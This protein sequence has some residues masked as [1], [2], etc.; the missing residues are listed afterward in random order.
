LAD[1]LPYLPLVG[2]MIG[3][4]TAGLA[5]VLGLITQWHAGIGIVCV[6]FSSLLTGGMHLDGLADV[7]DSFGG[8]T[9]KRRLEIMKDSSIG[10]FGAAALV[11]VLVAKVAAISQIAGLGKIQWLV[12]PF[13][14]SRMVQ[15]QLIVSLPY[16]RAEGGTGQGFVEGAKVYHFLFAFIIAFLFCLSWGGPVG[17]VTVSAVFLLCNA[18][19]WWMR[20]TFGGVTGDLIGMGSELTETG[21]LMVMAFLA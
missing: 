8:W 7:F 4:A 6:V 16:A 10:S 18:L 19:A 17:L 5:Y 14:V 9:V 11:L 21:T 12:V 13:V 2:A 20:R 3:I 15:S 1:A